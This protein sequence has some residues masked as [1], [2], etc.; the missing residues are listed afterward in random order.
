MDLPRLLG[1]GGAKNAAKD[2]LLSHDS[3]SWCDQRAGGLADEVE[4]VPTWP[5]T[6][7]W[8]LRELIDQERRQREAMMASFL[9]RLEEVEQRVLRDSSIAASPAA[10]QPEVV[11]KAAESH[12]EDGSINS[13][14]PM[15]ATL[16]GRLEEVERK[17]SRDLAP[18]CNQMAHQMLEKLNENRIK[19]GTIGV[20]EP[21]WDMIGLGNADA[22]DSNHDDITTEVAHCSVSGGRAAALRNVSFAATSELQPD[23][24]HCIDSGGRAAASRNVTFAATLDLEPDVVNQDSSKT[25]RTKPASNATSEG[26]LSAFLRSTRSFLLGDEASDETHGRWISAQDQKRMDAVNCFLG[27]HGFQKMNERKRLPPMRMRYT[28][29]LHIAAESGD[30]RL[31]KMLVEEG[32]DPSLRNS[33]GKTALQVAE[34]KSRNGSHVGVVLYL[35]RAQN[36]A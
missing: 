17:V 27:E 3:H 15:L 6:I 19:D 35:S 10:M 21:F 22:V 4:S 14:E 8:H 29:A 12:I 7:T 26:H 30:K 33:A 11:G 28:H 24:A 1:S 34:A 16:L 31:V 13:I 18:E 36:R 2:K 20:M 25:I 9:G 23:V 5:S 32:S